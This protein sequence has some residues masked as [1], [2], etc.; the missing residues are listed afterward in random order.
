M[1][2]VLAFILL[3]S[4]FI[5]CKKSSD[6]PAEYI[7]ATIDGVEQ[8]FNTNLEL[9]T[10]AF[11]NNVH[12]PYGLRVAGKNSAGE[13]L[14]LVIHDSSPIKLRTYRSDSLTTIYL[15][16]PNRPVGY[17]NHDT[18]SNPGTVTITIIGS[19]LVE[20]TFSGTM[21][22]TPSLPPGTPNKLINGK[23]KFRYKS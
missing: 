16:A 6:A 9:D 4:L 3:L 15:T 5:S 14:T 12:L 2:K 18:A 8:S 7:T 21:F 22:P 10:G 13:R 17:I 1:K 19:G 11:D 20:G 23:F